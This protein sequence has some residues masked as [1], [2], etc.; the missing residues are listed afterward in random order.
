VIA[1]LAALLMACSALGDKVYLKDGSVLE[2][3]ITRE[4]ELF[5]FIEV[6]SGG[7]TD[8]RL[9]MRE[10]IDR[11]ERDTP[12]ASGEATPS[13][14]PQTPEREEPARE[15][16]VSESATRITYVSLEGTVGPYMNAQAL[17]ES[18]R[19]V[20]DQNPDIVVLVI[21][22]GG[23]ALIEVRELSNVIERQL[24]PNYRVVVWVNSAISAAAMTAITCEEIYFQSKGNLG[25][26]TGF[27]GSGE[28]IDGEELELVL[29]EMEQI[30]A[31]GNHNPLIMRAMQIGMDLSC[32]IDSDGRV[33]W[34]E[35]LQGQHIVSTEDRILT[36]NALDAMKYKL[37]RGIA[38]TKEELASVLGA[39]EWVEIGYEADEYQH[40]FRENV[41][42]GEVES[43]KVLA[44][45]SEAIRRGQ[46][47]QAQRYLGQLRSWARRAPS[48]VKYGSGDRGVPPLTR[49]FFRQ[50]EEQLDEL[51]KRQ[52]QSNRNRR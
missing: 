12:E 26:A 14:S 50:L 5:V 11:I 40:E 25:A 4:G 15:P 20:E 7:I 6:S 3:T 41:A 18:I 21:D 1:A 30:S 24:K 36:L 51:R 10:N 22:S 49:A 28:A 16:A 32:D 42:R 39:D 8:E 31:R 27:R 19:L 48:L 9:V 38:D 46:L 45:Y 13:V 37:A 17:R 52:S 44:L 2:G 33:T 35:D 23:G 29:R 43:A 47:G 34:R